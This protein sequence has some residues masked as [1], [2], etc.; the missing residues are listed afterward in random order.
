[1][2]RILLRKL[3]HF[4]IC[5]TPLP[6]WSWTGEFLHD[7]S[8]LSSADHKVFE[9]FF[10]KGHLLKKWVAWKKSYIYCYSKILASVLPREELLI[11]LINLQMQNSWLQTKMI[12]LLN[13]LLTWKKFGPAK[14][15]LFLKNVSYACWHWLDPHN[16]L[17][18]WAFWCSGLES[19]C[20]RPE[21]E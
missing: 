1:M 19:R 9:S 4:D 2:R 6:A 8:L 12:W 17:N 21:D 20:F 3:W 18:C 13:S 5:A 16:W 15:H 14:C 11:L 10:W 7:Y